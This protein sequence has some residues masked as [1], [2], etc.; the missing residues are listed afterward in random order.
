MCEK[1]LR[2]NN[3]KWTM[4]AV[5]CQTKAYNCHF[6]YVL[7]YDKLVPF[8]NRKWGSCVGNLGFGC[9]LHFHF[10]WGWKH[11]ANCTTLPTTWCQP[12]LSK[13]FVDRLL[14]FAS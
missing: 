6:E 5:L 12:G 3:T 9:A 8:S 7:S 11:T 10:P 1:D 14:F 2:S 4:N 13:S